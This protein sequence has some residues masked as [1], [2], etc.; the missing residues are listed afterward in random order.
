MPLPVN[1]HDAAA[2]VSPASQ[3]CANVTKPLTAADGSTNGTKLVWQGQWKPQTTTNKN[4]SLRQRLLINAWVYWIYY[5]C[6]M[7]LVL[8]NTNRALTFKC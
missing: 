1:G 5:Y 3:H 8:G 7:A 4:L 2:N 6:G